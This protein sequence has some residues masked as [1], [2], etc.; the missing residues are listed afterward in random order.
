MEEGTHTT[1]ENVIVKKFVQ[2]AEI[3][4]AKVSFID[5][6]ENAAN[7]VE[8]VCRN[9]GNSSVTIGAPGLIPHE[10]ETLSEKLGSV[11]ACCLKEGLRGQNRGIN[12]G[13]SRVDYG[14]AETGTLV[15]NCPKEDHRLAS[16]ICDFHVCILESSNVVE[17]AFVI[18]K[19]LQKMM[20]SG[21]DYTAFITGPSRTADIERVLTIGVHGPLELHILIMEGA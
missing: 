7:Y 4:A 10:F 11:G 6:F 15:L 13:V 19:Q 12:V 9:I 8:T 16:M 20:L 14:I 5:C 18:E 2:R 17:D 1:I 3:M 21:P